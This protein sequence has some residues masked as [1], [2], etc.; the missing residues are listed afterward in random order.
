MVTA[1]VVQHVGNCSPD[2]RGIDTVEHVPRHLARPQQARLLQ[3][4]QVERQA[5]CRDA[6][7]LGDLARSHAVFALRG[8]QA[9]QVKPGLGWPA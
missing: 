7:R 4:G 5:R 3:R 9:D 6:K 8:Q 1:A 2:P